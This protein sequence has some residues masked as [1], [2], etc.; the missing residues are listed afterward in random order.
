MLPLQDRPIQDLQGKNI[1]ILQG[2]S[3]AVIESDSTRRLIRWLREAGATVA[4]LSVDAGHELSAQDLEAASRWLS[5]IPME[6]PA[7]ML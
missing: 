7:E 5:E 1:L 6:E 4:A 3:D 2:R